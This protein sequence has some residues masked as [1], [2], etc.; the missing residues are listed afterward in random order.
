MTT[1]PDENATGETVD[2]ATYSLSLH[3][4]VEQQHIAA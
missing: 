4:G 3:F 2:V 1:G